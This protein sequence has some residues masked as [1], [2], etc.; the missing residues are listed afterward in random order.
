M[1]PCTYHRTLDE[2]GH[3]MVTMIKR[4]IPLE[5]AEQ[6]HLGDGNETLSTRI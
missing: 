6:I 4:T 3:G 1:I 2:G 5:E